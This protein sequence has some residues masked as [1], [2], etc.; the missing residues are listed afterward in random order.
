MI[1]PDKLFGRLGNR[2][3]QMA[4]IYSQCER[5]LIPDIYVQDPSYFEDHADK[6]KER[7]R[8]GM[9]TSDLHVNPKKDG[10]AIHVRRG[11]YVDHPFYVDLMKTDYYEKAMAEFPDSYFTVFSDDIEWCKQQPI[12]KD[13]WQRVS[14]SEGRDELQDFNY[15]AR[16]TGIIIANS[17]YSWWAAYIAPFATKVVA[18]KAWH[19][20]GIQ[21]TKLLKEWKR[22]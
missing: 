16:H 10:V 5:G 13:N 3:F 9:Y 6:I 8:M 14:F 12:F 20:D 19:P 21:R 15:M 4:Y 7:F 22:I 2:L 18:P 11:D 17:S 1:H